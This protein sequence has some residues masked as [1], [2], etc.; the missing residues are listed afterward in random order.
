MPNHDA[1]NGGD[2]ERAAMKELQVNGY[3]VIKS[4]GSRGIVDLAAFKPGETL[5]VQ[6]KRTGYLDP[7]DRAKLYA[8]ARNH[9][10]IA[11]MSTWH[12]EGRAAR[13]VSF[14]ELAGTTLFWPWSPDY[15][16]ADANANARATESAT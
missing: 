11:L 3:Y 9:G 2:L 6:C 4:G 15:G 5:F 12:K 7:A 16:I 10:A 8:L 1:R 13:T 14:A